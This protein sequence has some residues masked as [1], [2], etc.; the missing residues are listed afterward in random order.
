MVETSSVARPPFLKITP[1]FGRQASGGNSKYLPF[2][3]HQYK[4]LFAYLNRIFIFDSSAEVTACGQIENIHVMY[5]APIKGGRAM[6]RIVQLIA[7][8][9]VLILLVSCG[10]NWEARGD[11]A[12]RTA[13]GSAGNIKRLK[14]KEAYMMYKSAVDEKGKRASRQLRERFVEMCTK[15]ATLMLTE[16]SYDLDAI[17]IFV[18]DLDKAYTPDL[19][20]QLLDGYAE[21]LKLMADSVVARDKILDAFAKMD[22]AISVAANKDKYIQAKKDLA[23]RFVT[24][25]FEEAKQ[26][27]TGGKASKDPEELV[28]AEYHIQLVLYMD[29]T[30]AEAQKLLSDIYRE[31]VGTYSAYLR[32][33]E[34]IPD[35]ALFRKIWRW[36]ILLAIP[37]QNI[38]G[39]SASLTVKMYNYANNPQRLFAK[40]FYLEDVSGNKYFASEGSKIEPEIL[41]QER[42]TELKLSF[43]GIKGEIKK[44]CYDVNNGEYRSEK[45]FF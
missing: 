23:T 27:Y 22:K 7:C 24:E 9:S 41:D 35:T 26:E 45:M 10:P 34:F 4:N 8:L 16:G 6:M 14:E 25:N 15:R 13:Q 12:Y 29:S 31:T 43:S 37:Q 42:E 30:N 2:I 39:G 19:P 17:P 21:L 20:G 1:E 32:V 40:S 36:H 44:L 18:A 38:K 11:R 28:R 3:P 5:L 33:V